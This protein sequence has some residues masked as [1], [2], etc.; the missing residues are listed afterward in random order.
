MQHTAQARRRDRLGEQQQAAFLLA[1][2]LARAG[3]ARYQQGRDGAAQHVAQAF[4]GTDTVEIVRESQIREDDVRKESL[5]KELAGS[6]SIVGGAG[7]EAPA[8]QQPLGR[9]AD[10]SVVVHDQC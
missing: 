5:I 2:E 9:F 1:G 6:G 3:V 4:N 10:R 7:I 8:A